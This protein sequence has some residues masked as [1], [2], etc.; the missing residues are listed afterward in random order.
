M[1][2]SA[3]DQNYCLASPGIG[4]ERQGQCVGSLA[5]LIVHHGLFA[6]CESYEVL[7]VGVV[8]IYFGT[9]FDADFAEHGAMLSEMLGEGT[10][11][12]AV[13]AWNFFFLKP[14]SERTVGQPMAV[15]EGVVLRN[16][17]AA[18]YTRTFVVALKGVFSTGWG[19]TVIA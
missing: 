9:A 7:G 17:C 18:V 5:E 16:N 19:N 11:V 12:D 2:Y 4:S 6:R 8:E 1:L 14:L 3:V 15:V 13:D 10:G